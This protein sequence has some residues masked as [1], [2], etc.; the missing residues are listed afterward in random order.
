MK[1]LVLIVSSFLPAVFSFGQ[2]A[3]NPQIPPSGLRVKSQLWNLSL[4]NTSTATLQVRVEMTM[5]DVSNNQRVLSGVSNSIVLPRGMKQLQPSNLSPI[6]YNMIGAGYNI[7]P[8][9]DG[10]LPLG[11][12]NVCYTVINMNSD[13]HGAIAEACE[14]A[15]IDAISPPQLVLPADKDTVTIDRPLFNWLPPS[16]TISFNG[17]LYDWTLTEIAPG[18]TAIEALQVNNP[19]LRMQNVRTNHFQYPISSPP[20][21]KEKIYAWGVVAKNNTAPVASS[22][23]WTFSLSSKKLTPIS[24]YYYQLKKGEDGSLVLCNGQLHY[25]YMNE[26]NDKNVQI[27]VYDITAS[28]HEFVFESKLPLR[29]GQNLLQLELKKG[30]YTDKHTYL[31]ELINSRQEKWYLK[32]EYRKPDQTN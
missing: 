27:S 2:V 26:A 12:F 19:V 30:K 22:D 1:K 13:A 25:E 21:E 14:T 24:S 8:N 11:I 15:E 18:Q 29:F 17:L 32:F 3:L 6:V 16:P 7:D 4:V 9:P 10:F 20:L 5:T 23:V 31:L 28:R